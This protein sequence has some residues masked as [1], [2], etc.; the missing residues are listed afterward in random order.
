MAVART[1]AT[2]FALMSP[3]VP[4]YALVPLAEELIDSILAASGRPSGQ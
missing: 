3:S 2:I 1:P 4:R